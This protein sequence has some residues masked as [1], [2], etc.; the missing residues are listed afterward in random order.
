MSRILIIGP[1]LSFH[2][3]GPSVVLGMI[4]ALNEQVRGCHFTLACSAPD[5]EKERVAT[6]Q[7]GLGFVPLPAGRAAKVST[8]ASALLMR[9]V[10]KVIVASPSVRCFLRAV[11]DADIVVVARA[12]GYID[13]RGGLGA[14]VRYG[15]QGYEFGVAKLLRK[16]TVQYTS[17]FGPL[18]QRWNRFFAKFWLGRFADVI[19][20]RSLESRRWLTDVGISSGKLMDAPDTG[21]LMEAA[22]SQ[23][24][25]KVLANC[26]G[27]PLV[28][29]GVSFQIRRRFNESARYD[30]L[31]K[32]LIRHLANDRG[33]HVL[34]IPNETHPKHEQVDDLRLAARIA[35][36]LGH[37]RV[38]FLDTTA[39]SG[40]EVKAVIRNCEVVVSSRYHTLLACL[41]TGVPC[42]GLG[43]HHKYGEMFRMFGMQQWTL[44]HTQ[45]DEATLIEMFGR[46]WNE[47]QHLRPVIARHLPAVEQAIRATA[48][49]VSVK[50]TA[51]IPDR[52]Q[53]LQAPNH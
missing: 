49:A 1:R 9:F 23:A 2:F 8:L 32:A 36:D 20:C 28:G 44:D 47:R 27:A 33:F 6:A 22:H 51:W 26:A 24:T 39:M 10:P 13:G 30:S 25:E 21:F 53:L 46:L 41:S 40:P 37:S 43:W 14:P 18:R 48:R 38:S 15:L 7:H 42:L 16:P 29:V 17:D 31:V 35:K 12:I 4:R 45:C 11:R 34:V 5:N 52:I 19:V 50:M 3:G